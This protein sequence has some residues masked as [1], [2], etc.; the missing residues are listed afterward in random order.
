MNRR[1]FN[2]TLGAVLAASMFPDQVLAA[3]D[4]QA[5]G[6]TGG[7]NNMASFSMENARN[8]AEQ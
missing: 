3:A 7:A 2:K 8:G 6:A 1:T 5:T 4:S